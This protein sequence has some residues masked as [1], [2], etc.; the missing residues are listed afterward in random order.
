MAF[1]LPF[2]DAPALDAPASGPARPVLDLSG[3]ALTQAFEALISGG[4]D[5]GGIESYATGLKS[6]AALFEQWLGGGRAAQLDLESFKLI[7]AHIAPVRRRVGASLEVRGFEFFREAIVELLD[8]AEDAATADLRIA[9]FTLRFPADREHRWVRDLA[10]ELLHTTYPEPYPLMCRWV[11]DAAANPGVLREI[12]YGE[13]VDHKTID[14]ADDYATFQMLREEL[15]QFLTDN[16]VFRDVL[17]YVDL[18]CAQVYAG[19]V[20]SQGGTYLRSDF[21][22]PEDPMQ[23]TR[24]LLGLDGLDSQTGRSRFK[25]AA[26][27]AELSH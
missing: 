3:P 2:L 20:D 15:S 25:E 7:C 24:R 6:K 11:W 26:G 10:A 1:R 5:Q 12:W 13:D 18:L 17:H 22:S 27:A 16:G 21:S 19:Y 14:V 9:D 8:G 23:Y 4:E